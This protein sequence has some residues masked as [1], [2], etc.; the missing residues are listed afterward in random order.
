MF[1]KMGWNMMELAYSHIDTQKVFYDL[2]EIPKQN[3]NGARLE[4]L[5]QKY[6][7]GFNTSILHNA[8]NDAVGTLHMYV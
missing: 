8:G 6:V 1:K 5:L 7:P 3:R 4:K 2:R